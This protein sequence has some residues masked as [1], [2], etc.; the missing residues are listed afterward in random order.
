MVTSV[1]PSAS[2]LARLGV[3][4][5]IQ[6]I[7]SDGPLDDSAILPAAHAARSDRMERVLE[8]AWLLGQRLGLPAEWERWRHL[9]LWVMPGLAGAMALSAW[10]LAQTVMGEGRSINAMAAFV[11]VLGPHALMLVLW[12]WGV[13]WTY[14][15]SGS[16]VGSGWS[17]GALA[18]RLTA[19]M[20]L[21]RGPHA[22]ALLQGVRR[23]LQRFRL[24]P[25]AFGLLSHAI[26][27]LAFGLILLALW[28]GFS[29]HAYRLSWETTILSPAFFEQFVH[30]T[31]WL[32]AQLGFP[33]PDAAAVR[34]AGGGLESD[35]R[36]W[37]W[38]LMGC[39]F[40]YG[41]L[42]RLLLVLLC[43]LAWKA[44]QRRL[45]LDSSDPYVRRLLARFDALDAAVVVDPE[46][47]G[48]GHAAHV[49]PPVTQP[50]APALVGF[51]LPP[52][53]P[54]P[55]E[56]WQPAWHPAVQWLER[57]A[58]SSLERTAVVQR[59]L[60]Q[61][62]HALLIATWGASS[63]DRGTAR[64]LREA[65]ATASRTAILLTG[66]GTGSTDRWQAW[67]QASGF[68]QIPVFVDMA[69]A[70]AWLAGAHSGEDN[71]HHD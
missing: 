9:G 4:H 11:T 34:A 13:I 45:A 18:L 61:R 28:F 70:D 41:L 49:L 16:A 1:P 44:G 35:Q 12:V 30:V 47:A 42:P 66:T 25:W 68:P 14:A 2:P 46:R 37:A 54:W 21:D 29:F 31:G 69:A 39:V 36:A 10:G 5:A 32:P 24:A 38:W 59:L 65:A 53:Q 52:E 7:E 15:G 67:L 71:S 64:F 22:A 3:A 43:W 27:A 62:P 58:G 40:C 33:V 20:P 8:R 56:R 17:L 60:E 23:V 63:P 48:S 51:E 50:G 19:R 57:I 6:A 55:P 26:W